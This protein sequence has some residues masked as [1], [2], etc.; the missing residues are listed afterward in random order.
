MERPG[1]MFDVG[2]FADAMDKLDDA[3]Q[4]PD[5]VVVF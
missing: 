5:E 2:M 1:C 3:Q 4:N